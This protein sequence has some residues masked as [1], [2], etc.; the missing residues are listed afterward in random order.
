MID[1]R[2]FLKIAGAVIPSWG[3]IPI[4]SAQSSLYTGKILINV[5]AS[6]GMDASSWADPRETDATMNNYAAAGTPAVVAGNIRA[7]PM[8]NNAAFFQRVLPEH[9]GHQRRQQR[10]QQPRRRHSGPCHRHA[11]DEL[12]EPVGAVRLGAGQGHTDALAQRRRLHDQRRAGAGHADAGRQLV[13]HV[14]LAELG[15][16]PRTTS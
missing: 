12:S 1:R 16:R 4:A 9:A 2:D 8:G 11:G 3:L 14:D 10:D 6:G 7:A 15:D 13:P 5:H